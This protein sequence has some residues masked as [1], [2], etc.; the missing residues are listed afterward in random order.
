MATPFD[1]LAQWG[2]SEITSPICSQRYDFDGVDELRAKRRANVPI[3]NLSELEKYKLAFTCALLRPVMLVY[4]VGI[5]DFDL[6][7]ID[8]H[9]LGQILA[10]PNAWRDSNRIFT[11]LTIIFLQRPM[12][13][14]TRAR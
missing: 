2:Y 8:R 11:H 6:I 1:V 3:E 10:A 12:K 9:V 7:A 13:T 4:M 5:D 14:A